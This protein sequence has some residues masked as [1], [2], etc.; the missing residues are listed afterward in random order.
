MGLRTF[1]H[2][3]RQ[4]LRQPLQRGVD[5]LGT[6]PTL[7]APPR[8]LGLNLAPAAPAWSL[9]RLSAIVHQLRAQPSAE[10]MLEARHA[11]HCLS[12]FWL[13]APVDQ[14]AQ[15]WQGAIGTVQRELSASPL[16]EQPLSRDEQRWRHRLLEAVA[17][18]SPDRWNHLLALL[19]YLEGPQLP[20]AITAEALPTWLNDLYS[21]C[22]SANASPRGLLTPA[23]EADAP[24]PAPAPLPRLIP[25]DGQQLLDLFSDEA[26]QKRGLGLLR[27]LQVDPDDQEVIDELQT[28]RLMLAQ[29]LLDVSPDSLENLYRSAI[30]DLFRQ[31]VQSSLCRRELSSRDQT[32]RDQLMQLLLE[33]D[34]GRDEALLL[35]VALFHPIERIE[36]NLDSFELP[37]WMHGAWRELSG[38]TPA[39]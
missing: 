24:G 10:L 5:L 35:A 30:G 14:L 9:Q 22:A 20:S 36:L 23:K 25:T 21:W 28:L 33:A 37:G 17:Q 7:F 38:G 13:E 12:R 31:L 39:R 1:W 34:T 18:S 6:Q 29:L 8:Q 15:L 3:G 4:R 19:G 2:R 16:R 26:A 32:H 11:R 27:L